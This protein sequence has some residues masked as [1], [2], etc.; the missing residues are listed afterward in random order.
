M[1]VLFAGTPAFAVPSLEALIASGHDVVGVLTMPDRR[2]GR[3]RR[4][5]PSPVKECA[6]AHGIPIHQPEK[7]RRAEWEKPFRDLNVDAIA[8]VAYGKILR[9]WLL[10]IPKHGC[11]NV[12]ASLLP[13]HRGPSPIEQAIRSGDTVTGITTM[14]IDQGVD[15]G[16]MLLRDEIEIEPGETAGELTARLAMIGGA[17]LV[18]T[19][20]R[21]EQGDCP[22]EQQDHALATHAPMIE[23]DDGRIDWTQ[24]ALV[25]DRLVRAM[26]PRP[27]AWTETPHGIMRV[28]RSRLLLPG[29]EEANAVEREGW[30]PGEKPG[31]VLAADAKCGLVMRTGKGVLRLVKV[32][33]PGRKA[34]PDTVLLRGVAIE[35]GEAWGVPAVTAGGTHE[36]PEPP[37][38]P[39]T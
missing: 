15:T 33:L 32:Q 5:S 24:G 25:I 4:T 37:E 18:E 11:I 12:H 29:T 19:L 30:A 3:G 28:L 17:L 1:R 26:N 20:D 7:L 6:T 10:A 36:T 34:M 31:A 16:D 39:A 14:R 9:P 2:R 35:P 21:L 13:K 8:I 27:I 23:K 38:T 22:S